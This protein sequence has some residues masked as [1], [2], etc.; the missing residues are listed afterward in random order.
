MKS[1]R[2]WVYRCRSCGWLAYLRTPMD[3]VCP[4]CGMDD[5]RLIAEVIEERT[6]GERE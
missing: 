6:K 2:R 3:A 1:L 4:R 5:L